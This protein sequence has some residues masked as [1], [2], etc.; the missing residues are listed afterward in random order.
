MYMYYITPGVLAQL[1]VDMVGKFSHQVSRGRIS[2]VE[3]HAK[4]R[5]YTHYCKT[6]DGEVYGQIDYGFNKEGACMHKAWIKFDNDPTTKHEVVF[7]NMRGDIRVA[8]SVPVTYSSVVT[9]QEVKRSKLTKSEIFQVAMSKSVSSLQAP[10]N[11]EGFT[12][13][14]EPEDTYS[15]EDFMAEEVESEPTSYDAEQGME[16]FMAG[17]T[18]DV[19][20]EHVHTPLDIDW[21]SFPTPFF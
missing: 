3:H 5:S 11:T 8:T 14:V 20:P 7:R 6:I 9:N 15:L 21:G 17:I 12:L 16:D 1:P 10:S 4:G 18:F 13:W 2:F 19:Y